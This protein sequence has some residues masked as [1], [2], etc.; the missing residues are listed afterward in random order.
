MKLEVLHQQRFSSSV[1]LIKLESNG[2][3]GASGK[4]LSK[5]T[6][7]F[8][9]KL[10]SPFS[11]FTK[12]DQ[13]IHEDEIRFEIK[14]EEPGVSIKLTEINESENSVSLSSSDIPKQKKQNV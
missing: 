14:E 11:P 7:S 9:S 10:P 1:R 8:K 2:N 5:H 6:G 3:S 12:L 4:K 13:D